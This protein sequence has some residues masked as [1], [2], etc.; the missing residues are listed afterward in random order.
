MKKITNVLHI[1]W[2]GVYLGGVFIFCQLCGLVILGPREFF[3][4]GPIN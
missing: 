2:C 4:E 3:K 1:V